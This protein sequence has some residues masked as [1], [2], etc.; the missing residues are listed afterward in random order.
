[1]MLRGSKRKKERSGFK[2]VDTFYV[3]VAAPRK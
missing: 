3:S 1:M 2:M